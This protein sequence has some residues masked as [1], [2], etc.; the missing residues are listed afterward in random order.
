M[1]AARRTWKI[2]HGALAPTY[3]VQLART[4]AE[5]D[6]DH[7]LPAMWKEFDALARV[8]VLVIRGA[9]SDILS[10]A[11]VNAMRARHP[12]LEYIEVPD[13]GHVPLLEG[14]ELLQR[15]ATFVEKCDRV[16]ANA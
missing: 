14:V 9:N 4:L 8:L 16:T 7:P 15:I 13:Q 1:T 2:E 10:A 11:T 3:D 12:A 6:I 5:F